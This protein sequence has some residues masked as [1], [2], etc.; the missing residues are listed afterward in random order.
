MGGWGLCPLRWLVH[1]KKER[2]KNIDFKWLLNTRSFVGNMVD[3]GHKEMLMRIA[4]GRKKSFV[5]HCYYL[6]FLNSILTSRTASTRTGVTESSTSRLR[7]SPTTSRARLRKK[8]WSIW[9]CSC[10]IWACTCP[11]TPRFG[12]Y[13]LRISCV[14]L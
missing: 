10:C 2:K 12:L 7:I 1:F 4:K 6:K 9:L 13:R 5:T 8:S 11:K 3:R 14:N